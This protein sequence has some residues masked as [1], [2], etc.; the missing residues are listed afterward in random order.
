MKKS[1]IY[2]SLCVLAVLFLGWSAWKTL[3][4]ATPKQ[5]TS[6]EAARADIEQ[7]DAKELEAM[8]RADLRDEVSRRQVTLDSAKNDRDQVGIDRAT[9]A[10]AR[11][12]EAM[13]RKK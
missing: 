12:T 2:I 6:P 11:A 7:L 5:I 10:L 1:V 13:K 4:S 3:S 9:S 8:S